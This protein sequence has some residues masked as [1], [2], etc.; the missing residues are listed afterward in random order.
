[1][2]DE[3][4]RKS[5]RLSRLGQTVKDSP[6]GPAKDAN[7][8]KIFSG[9]FPENFDGFIAPDGRPV[10]L[11]D[12]DAMY[13]VITRR[14]DRMA[15]VVRALRGLAWECFDRGYPEAACACM[16]KV[17]PLLDDPAESAACLLNMGQIREQTGDWRAALEVYSRAFELPKERNEIWYFLNNNLAYCLNLD[18]RYEEAEEHCRTAIRIDPG[19]HNA[20]KNLGIALQARGQYGAAAKSF[21]LATR[22]CPVDIRALGLLRELVAN[23]REILEEDPEILAQLLESH[24]VAQSAKGRLRPQ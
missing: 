13:A 6:K 21:L 11:Q 16:E 8:E 24:E 22:L 12:A 23:H 3:S 2:A 14:M 5:N 7:G 15:D 10:A 17:L 19:R 20:H 9:E 4:E 1:M 18:R